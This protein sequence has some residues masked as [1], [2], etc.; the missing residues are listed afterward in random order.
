[1]GL[2]RAAPVVPAPF[3]TALP[4][5]LRP[6]SGTNLARTAG[7]KAFKFKAFFSIKKEDLPLLIHLELRD[8]YWLSA[9][10]VVIVSSSLECFALCGL[11]VPSVLE[12]L[13]LAGA[14][15]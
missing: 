1:M 14:S 11:Y 15:F 8:V 4:P 10:K 7:T 6:T 12:M 5:Q 9:L 13:L 3:T 2:P